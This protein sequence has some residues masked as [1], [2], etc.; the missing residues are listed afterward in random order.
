MKQVDKKLIL[1]RHIPFWNELSND[2]KEMLVEN[3]YYQMHKKG[4]L[5]HGGKSMC[6]GLIYVVEGRLRAYILSEEGKEININELDSNSLCILSA[7]CVMGSQ[8]KNFYLEAL[9]NSQLINIEVSILK[10]LAEKYPSVKIYLYELSSSRYTS[11][12]KKM[13][14]MLFY[15]VEKRLASRLLEEYKSSKST[16]IKTTHESLAKDIGS[17]REVVSRTLNELQDKGVVKLSR[18]TI[19]I[20]QLE[21]IRKMSI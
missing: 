14:D 4:M 2:D 12:V 9:E 13:Q 17:V 1:E 16:I 20:L 18:G 6:T 5:V 8:F 7:S 19:E 15:S 3:S 11:M 10:K 21:T